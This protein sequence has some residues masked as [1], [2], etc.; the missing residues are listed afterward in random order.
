MFE[1]PRSMA[2]NGEEKER[3]RYLRVAADEGLDCDIEGADVVHIV[4]V[5]S[6]GRGMRVITNCELPAEVELD[7]KLVW[8]KEELFAGKAKAVWQETWDFEFCS[9]H[10]AGIELLGLSDE[11]RQ[12]LVGRLP[13]MREPSPLP[14]E[15]L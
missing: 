15:M 6:E 1:E 11:E 12:A 2:V 3:R 8:E 14:E 7:L 5:S 10:V 4:G 9:R 13:V